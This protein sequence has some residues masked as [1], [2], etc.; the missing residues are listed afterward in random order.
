MLKFQYLRFFGLHLPQMWLQMEGPLGH[1]PGFG[2][3]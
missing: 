1:L 3:D 2:G